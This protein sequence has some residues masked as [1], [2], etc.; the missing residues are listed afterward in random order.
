MASSTLAPQVY[1]ADEIN[2]VVLDPGSYS[3]RVGFAGCDSPTL[4]LPSYYGERAGKYPDD[5]KALIFDENAL[6]SRPPPGMVIKPILSSDLIQDWN[7]AVE[8]YEYMFKRMDVDPHEQPILFTESTMNSHKNMVKAMEVFLE[9]EQFCAFYAVKQPTCVS[10]AHGRPNCLV[11]DI[12]HDL[13]TVTPVIDGLCLKK[14]VMGTRYAGAFLNQQLRQ[15][16]ET[17]NIKY[18]PIYEV[19]SKVP[20]YWKPEDSDTPDYVSRD[21]KYDIGPSIVQF[22]YNRTLQEMK[23]TLFECC[24]VE[25]EVPQVS[26]GSDSLYFEL[27]NGYNV[28]FSKY[29]RQKLSNSL[30]NPLET[31]EPVIK[32]W[33]KP[34]D[35][36]IIDDIGT[37]ND[38]TSKEYIPMRRTKRPD[39]ESERTKAA[40]ATLEKEKTKSGL[41]ISRL[42]QTV[43]NRT[44]IDLRPQLA[45]NIVLTGATSLIPRLNE[46][47]H[48]ELT[49]HNP[50]LKIRIHSVGN[51]TERKYSSWIG[52]SILASLGTF[53]Q[54]WVSKQEYDEVGPDKLIF[55]RFR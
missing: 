48:K 7:G 2:A 43:L 45:N 10:F 54:L 18:T 32:G 25:Q 3:T 21:F 31:L 34:H 5:K 15:F 8:Q 51:T 24:R 1:G 53:H 50:S 22:N 19:K 6:Y 49:D 37:R 42:I 55:N 47:L 26:D 30:F 14:Q 16:L 27:P 29:E 13:L 12:G 38:K 44:D 11:V 52:G 39:I 9:K 33:E 41:G 36:N 46:R 28:P 4:V 20:K 35:G 40:K 23:E 17:R